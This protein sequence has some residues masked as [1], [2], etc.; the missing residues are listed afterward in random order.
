MRV[1][2]NTISFGNDTPDFIVMPQAV[3]EFFEAYLQP[4]ER[5]TNTKAANVG[6]SNLTFK[7][8]PTVFDRDAISGNIFLL[9]SKYLNLCVHRDANIATGKFIEPE[10]QDAM[11]AKILFQGNLTINN[12]R[13]HGK[14]T[15]ITA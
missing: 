3:Y 10:N 12:R 1:V 13:M 7:S 11:S 5:Y 8:I 6:F 14:I 9:N 2:F 4:Q 15:G